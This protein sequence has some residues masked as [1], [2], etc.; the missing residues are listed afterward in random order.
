MK[1]NI[2]IILSFFVICGIVLLS[3]CGLKQKNTNQY[4][5]KLEVWGIFDDRDAFNDIFETYRKLNPNVSSIE[6]KKLT[7]DTY[8]KE[9]MEALASG[10]GPDIFMIHNDW[11]PSF[12]NTIVAAPQEI[13]SEQKFRKDF[14]DVVIFDFLKEGRIFAAP[15]SVDSLGLYYNK[16]LFNEAG[17]TSPPK[18]WNEFVEYV[19]KLTRI[20]AYGQ[21]VKSGAAI[22]T[23]YNINR[24]ADILSLLMLQNRTEMVNLQNRRATFDQLIK[25]G[26]QTAFPGENALGFYTQFAAN[27]AY[28]PY[29]WSPR[30]HYSLDAFSEGTVGMMLNYSWHRKTIEGKAP[31]LNFEVAPVPQSNSPAVNFADYWGYAVAKNKI[32]ST[33]GTA[34]AAQISNETRVAEAW[35]FLKFLTVNPEGNIAQA[36]NVAGTKQVVDPNYD[37]AVKYLQATGRPA[38]RKDIIER[39]K[40]D[41]RI[42]VF[43]ESN[44]VAKS[45]VQA[46]PEAIEIIF[47]EMI[48]QVNRGASTP[49]EAIKAGAAR[50]TQLMN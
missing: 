29:A 42:G 14:A 46:D 24:S 47:A 27:S 17:I 31:K 26:D 11:L 23:A 20:D 34:R 40:T 37:P 32:P 16:D 22:G 10:Q 9:I 35:K 15:L 50:V 25:T 28:T 4:S 7:Y 41:P 45:W 36:A 2:K 3:G 8:K 43:A 39:Q 48:D 1:T 44:L 30:M 6:Y 49:A 21:I 38:A 5:L 12:A 13:I 33:L 19:R 18:D